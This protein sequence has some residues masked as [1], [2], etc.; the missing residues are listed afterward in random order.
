[1]YAEFYYGTTGAD[2][3]YDPEFPPAG[4]GA[5]RIRIKN[6]TQVM[7]LVAADQAIS[8]TLWQKS[9][10]PQELQGKIHQIHE[11][12]DTQ[13]I[14]PAPVIPPFVTGIRSGKRLRSHRQLLSGSD[15]T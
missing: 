9:R 2:T 11:G 14:A 1:V 3:G 10:Y 5:W 15:A 6:S 4:D 7:S 13:I 8:P 12:I